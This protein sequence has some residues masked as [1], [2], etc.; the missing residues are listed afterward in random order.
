MPPAVARV[1]PWAR[2]IRKIKLTPI[3]PPN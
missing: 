3:F 2:K 1:D